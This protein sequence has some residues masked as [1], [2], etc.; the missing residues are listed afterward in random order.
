MPEIPMEH[1]RAAMRARLDCPVDG[2]DGHVRILL[3]SNAPGDL[4]VWTCSSGEHEWYE[5]GGPRRGVSWAIEVEY[6]EHGPGRYY[7]RGSGE[8]AEP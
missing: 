4:L 2:C 5:D 1:L 3:T 7:A 8:R 6:V